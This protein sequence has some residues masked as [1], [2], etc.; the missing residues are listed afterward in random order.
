MIL[1]KYLSIIK[2]PAKNKSQPQ[3][4]KFMNLQEQESCRDFIPNDLSTCRL[5]VG[6]LQ[7][8]K[9]FLIAFSLFSIQPTSVQYILTRIL[10]VITGILSLVVCSASRE[11]WLNIFPEI[12]KK[13]SRLS[14]LWVRFIDLVS[15]WSKFWMVD[16]FSRFVLNVSIPGEI[17]MVE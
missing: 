5:L 11:F 9:T 3:Q 2:S 6:L 7:Y 14:S 4:T 16:R 13:F 15:G 17:K 10:L 12:L 1:Y 8:F